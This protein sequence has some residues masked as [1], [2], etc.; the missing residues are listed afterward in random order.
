M[1]GSVI[2][3]TQDSNWPYASACWYSASVIDPVCA[4]PNALSLS[5]RGD[6]YDSN[7]YPLVVRDGSPPRATGADLGLRCAYPSP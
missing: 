4:E 6:A 5:I 1:T 2:E 7:G 3:W